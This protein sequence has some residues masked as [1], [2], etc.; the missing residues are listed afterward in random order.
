M[1][2]NGIVQAIL[3]AVGEIN[4]KK[5]NNIFVILDTD[6]TQFI[7]DKKCGTANIK[8]DENTKIFDSEDNKISYEE[9]KTNDKITLKYQL[10]IM[11]N[12]IFMGL[13]KEIRKVS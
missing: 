9:L 1:E 3:N 8:V 2:K 6:K 10:E 7:D 4:D 11:G 13:A 12:F 5:E